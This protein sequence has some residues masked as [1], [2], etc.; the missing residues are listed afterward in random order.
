MDENQ[1]IMVCESILLHNSPTQ[2]LQ[3]FICRLLGSSP[4]PLGL[5]TL[6]WT[7]IAVS[8]NRLKIKYAGGGGWAKRHSMTGVAAVARKRR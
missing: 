7:G 1:E 5:V 6:T 2:D 4:G 3:N 8:R